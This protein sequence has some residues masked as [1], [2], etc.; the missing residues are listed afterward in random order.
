MA[1]FDQIKSRPPSDAHSWQINMTSTVQWC[2]DLLSFV[3]FQPPPS[4]QARTRVRALVEEETPAHAK[5]EAKQQGR[6]SALKAPSKSFNASTP[7][8]KDPSHHAQ[9]C[10]PNFTNISAIK[11]KEEVKDVRRMLATPE[12]RTVMLI[13][14]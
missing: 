2:S 3:L 11:K 5:E 12:G 9:I 14:F 6:S 10:S 4:G 13:E 8:S 7:V 1:N